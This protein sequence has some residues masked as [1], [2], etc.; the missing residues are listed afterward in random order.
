MLTD[1]SEQTRAD[2]DSQQVEGLL[3]RV[4]GIFKEFEGLRGRI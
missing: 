2:E 1:H 3:G 4:E